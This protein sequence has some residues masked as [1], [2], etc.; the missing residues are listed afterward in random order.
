MSQNDPLRIAV[1]LDGRP[2]HEKQTLGIVKALEQNYSLIIEKINVS[3]PSLSSHLYSLL[4]F[5]V[6]KTA[7]KNFQHLREFDL[8]IGTGT[9]THLPM[10][11][12]KR[13][14]N[15]PVITC[16]SPAFYLASHFDLI[17]SPFHD[18]AQESDNRVI[19]TGPPNTNKNGNVHNEKKVL[20]LVGGEDKRKHIW[21]SDQ[22]VENIRRLC[23]SD[24]T[25]YFTISSSPRTPE[26]TC[27]ELEKLSL[28]QDNVYFYHFKDTPK[29]W[30]EDQ[31]Q[32]H[33]EVWVTG[34]SI[35]MVYEALSSGCAV[36]IIPVQWKQKNSKFKIS[37]NYLKEK[38][39][40]VD[41][42]A[43]LKGEPLQNNK[44]TLNEA[45][46][47]AKEIIKRILCQN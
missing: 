42:N 44:P 43:F 28:S 13:A 30:V 18:K 1:F 20:I 2:G 8:L 38:G 6:G 15:I 40:T 35:S 3:K 39:L 9:H 46:R 34:D 23:K 14:Y 26:K 25:K 4:Y 5:L 24:A 36:G 32:I 31:Y 27:K 22:I 45:S 7:T 41:L 10:L 11:F 12:C 17:F 16:M 33:R 29:G 47:C 21:H 19:T 37:E